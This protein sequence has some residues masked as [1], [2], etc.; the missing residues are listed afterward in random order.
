MFD[1]ISSFNDIAETQ[2]DAISGNKKCPWLKIDQ[3][4]YIDIHYVEQIIVRY[5]ENFGVQIKDLVGKC[6]KNIHFV[7]LF[8]VESGVKNTITIGNVKVNGV[9]KFGCDKSTIL[10]DI[11]R[12]Y[13]RGIADAHAWITLPNGAI[14][15]LSILPSSEGNSFKK[16][17]MRPAKCIFCSSK[18]YDKVYE[19]IPLYLGDEY[20]YRV[21]LQPDDK[22]VAFAQ[23]SAQ[24]I[25]N[26]L[27]K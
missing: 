9:A 16:K 5:Y 3:E 8:L 6:F 22:S 7:S 25:R 26:L 1:Y 11:D 13:E 14:I 23:I 10:G 21:V 24:K 2:I 18:K 19:H 20:I 17:H 12:G 27:N 15:D 4:L